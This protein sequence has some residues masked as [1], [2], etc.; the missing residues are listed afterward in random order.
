MALELAPAIPV[1]RG[2][3]AASALKIRLRSL[4]AIS[5]V[6]RP[7]TF[8]CASVNTKYGYDGSPY[9]VAAVDWA[10]STKTGNGQCSPC[11]HADGG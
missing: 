7:T 5:P 1:G 11:N 6:A 9:A 4:G 3:P 8:P 2:V 10:L